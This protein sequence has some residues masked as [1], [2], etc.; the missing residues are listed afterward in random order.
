MIE[1]TEGLPREV[2]IAEAHGRVSADDYDKVLIPAL[3][4]AAAGGGKLRLLYVLAE[5][6]DGFEAGAALED[7]KLGVHHWGD[8]ERIGM[9]SDHE[10]Y[11]M[12]AEVFGFLMPGAFRAFS[13][14]DIEAAR[15]DHRR[16]T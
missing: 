8:F 5:D 7:T 12:L 14:A 10:A 6:F 16:S 15:V 3:T 11:R 9:V 4:A 13:L 1:L 2:I